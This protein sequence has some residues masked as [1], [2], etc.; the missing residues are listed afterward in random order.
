MDRSAWSRK[1]LDTPLGKKQNSSYTNNK[2]C[3]QYQTQK[4][5]RAERNMRCRTEKVQSLGKW[6]ICC[7]TGKE[8]RKC[9]NES[10]LFGKERQLLTSKEHE[11][12]KK[13]N[14][15]FFSLKEDSIMYKTIVSPYHESET[16]RLSDINE[17]TVFLLK[18][19]YLLL[20]DFVLLLLLLSLS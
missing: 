19:Y 9:S 5:F 12:K 16:S 6:N 14:P 1:G 4:S 2:C 8:A 7:I 20:G 15:L 17:N 13:Q 18:C 3:F 10:R 11:N